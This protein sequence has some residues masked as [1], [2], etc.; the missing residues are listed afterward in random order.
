[1]A[2]C[3]AVDRKQALYQL[4]TAL[5]GKDRRLSYRH[6]TAEQTGS[7]S[8]RPCQHWG[9]C[10]PQNP[11]LAV[12]AEQSSP[13][14]KPSPPTPA[15]GSYRGQREEACV[16]SHCSRVQL[17][18]DPMDGSPPGSSVHGT[19]LERILEWV[20]MPSSRGSSRPRDW[21]HISCITGRF[22]TD[23]ATKEAQ[24]EEGRFYI[25]MALSQPH[26]NPT[27]EKLVV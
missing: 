12:T 8:C 26:Q 6:L 20:A 15:R 3:H 2:G 25:P 14:E 5:P 4:L 13:R 17:I 9:S 24:R 19:F 1:M 10:H 7:Y 23:W 18:H 21:T 16:L 11:N 22:L 27:P